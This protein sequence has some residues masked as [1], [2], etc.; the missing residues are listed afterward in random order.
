[1]KLSVFSV[2]LQARYWPRLQPRESERESKRERET[3][4]EEKE[5]EKRQKVALSCSLVLKECIYLPLISNALVNFLSLFIVCT[6]DLSLAAYWNTGEEVC[7]DFTWSTKVC[8]L[9]LQNPIQHKHTP[10]VDGWIML[11]HKMPLPFYS[12]LVR[13][14]SNEWPFLWMFDFSF[15]TSSLQHKHG[16]GNVIWSEWWKRNRSLGETF[17]K[18]FSIQHGGLRA[19]SVG[20]SNMNLLIER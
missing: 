1:M 15:Q 20:R 11:P 7:W 3:E 19:Q 8:L 13:H 18:R 16:N 12:E 10:A 2:P 14:G 6:W 5:R 4:N 17:A 9:F